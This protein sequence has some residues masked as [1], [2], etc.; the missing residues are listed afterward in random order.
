[1]NSSAP[2]LVD[3]SNQSITEQ[4]ECN[5]IRRPVPITP[6]SF[7]INPQIQTHPYDRPPPRAPPAVRLQMIPRHSPSENPVIA[8]LMN[9]VA[10]A[11]DRKRLREEAMYPKRNVGQQ[12]EGDEVIE[13]DGY[14]L[15]NGI[16]STKR[17]KREENANQS[18]RDVSFETI[19][20]NTSPAPIRLTPVSS[21][22][23]SSA[24]P[25]TTQPHRSSLHRRRERETPAAR[26]ARRERRERQQQEETIRIQLENLQ[27]IDGLVPGSDHSCNQRCPHFQHLVQISNA[28]YHQS[29]QSGPPPTGPNAVSPT[30]APGAYLRGGHYVNPFSFNYPVPA[31][32][33]QPLVPVL[34]GVYPVA[35]T[36]PVIHAPV[37]VRPPPPPPGQAAA[38]HNLYS[39][40]SHNINM[41]GYHPELY[42]A[43]RPSSLNYLFPSMDRFGLDRHHMFAGLDIDVPVGAS[44]I[45]IDNFTQPTLYVKKEGEEEDDT[46]TVCLSNFE[47]GESIRKLPCN[48]VFHPECI[49]KWLDINKK[50]PMCRE[51]IDRIRILQQQ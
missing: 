22:S 50:C 37:A 10:A 51:D 35:P 1:M 11:R 9:T 8:S 38:I 2:V 43:L 32:A 30:I 44:K 31:F 39:F 27:Q 25:S 34:M 29:Q 42:D 5:V 15:D 47:D 36:A 48:H 18:R 28:L 17:V 14:E 21:E 4:I 23:S 7:C 26:Q 3:S 49:Y 45:E 13:Q 16:S 46:C 41:P 33:P 19:G 12:T 40:R 20:T 6:G 24:N